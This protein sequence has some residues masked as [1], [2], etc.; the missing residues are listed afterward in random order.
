MEDYVA[1]LEN[2][3]KMYVVSVEYVILFQL[4]FVLQ[5]MQILCLLIF[6]VRAK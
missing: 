3:L 2:V 5:V 4:I 6:H 1:K